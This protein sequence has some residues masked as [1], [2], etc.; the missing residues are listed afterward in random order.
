MKPPS[1][2][3][4]RQ[5]WEAAQGVRDATGSQTLRSV[6]IADSELQ[7]ST[8]SPGSYESTGDWRPSPPQWPQPSESPN[9]DGPKPGGNSPAGMH[10]EKDQALVTSGTDG[11]AFEQALAEMLQEATPA[12]PDKPR[13]IDR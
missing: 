10:A 1:D 7:E 3:T 8:R 11:N 5:A 6:T 13:N 9:D 4:K 2:E 12:N